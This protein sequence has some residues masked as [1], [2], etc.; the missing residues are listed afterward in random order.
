MIGISNHDHPQLR[1]MLLV[2]S[3]ITAEDWFH[4]LQHNWLFTSSSF[5]CLNVLRNT[6]VSNIQIIS[7][8]KL[9]R[10]SPYCWCCMIEWAIF[11][12]LSL[13]CSDGVWFHDRNYNL[14]LVELKLCKNDICIDWKTSV[15]IKTIFIVGLIS[16]NVA[17][18]HVFK[19]LWY[20]S[21]KKRVD[22]N[23][24]LSGF[25]KIVSIWY[26]LI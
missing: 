6:S 15:L 10:K 12:H 11:D 13:F 5:L 1:T 20:F 23:V 16:L 21:V 9:L 18:K 22:Q 26:R 4:N 14:Y 8:N 24:E 25:D 3:C 19:L 2:S 17:S 7:D